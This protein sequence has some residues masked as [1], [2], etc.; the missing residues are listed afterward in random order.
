M[1]GCY[2]RSYNERKRESVA[3]DSQHCRVCGIVKLE[4]ISEFQSLPRV[5]SD[6]LAF[7]AGGRLLVCHHCGAAQ[8]P[9]DEQWFD[10]IQEIYSNYHAYH[11]SGGQEQ[12]VLDPANGLLRSRSDVLLDRLVT[13][14]GVP[15]SG[16]VMDVGCGSGGTLRAF[17][18]RGTWRLY[19]L[20][21]DER[22]LPFLTAITGFERLYTGAPA[23]LP[24]QFDLVTM[25]HALE[26]FPE[27]LATMR[28]LGSKIAPGG[29][30]FVE[31][32]NAEA[33]PFD[34]LIADHMM[35]FTPASLSAMA[36]RAGFNIDCLATNWVTKELS[37]TARPSTGPLPA[38]D[39]QAK[40]EVANDV[41][42]QVGW[43]CRVV[44]AAS[45]ALA[46]SSNFGLF[47]TSIAATW[48]CGVLGS[49]VSF[50]VE[51]DLSRVGRLYMERPVVSPPQVRAGSTVFMALV[52]Q[53]ADQIARRLRD[54]AIDMRLPPN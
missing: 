33:N 4:E 47:G 13:V 24:G 36:A 43:L 28:D 11:Q 42:T 30:L 3:N 46:E 23:D 7:R 38:P 53:I 31:V 5:T 48:L 21:M 51:E 45:E 54:T 26:H 32:P 39:Q 29:R 2:A 50:F 12:H 44:V 18:K 49:A 34:Y 35:H 14:P 22:N 16:A 17:S 41:R 40:S 10:E 37:L 19:G 15:A 9:A 8:S 6:C 20:E 1:P 27:P 25:V 52:P